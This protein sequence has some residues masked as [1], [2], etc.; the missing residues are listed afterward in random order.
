[1]APS[2]RNS[3]QSLFE[4]MM[5]PTSMAAS[6]AVS[7]SGA[8]IVSGGSSNMASTGGPADSSDSLLVEVQGENSAYYKAYV[9]DIFEGE[10]LLRFEDDWQPESKFPFARVRLPPHP[11]A[12]SSQDESASSIAHYTEGEEIEVFSRASDQ[13]SC[14]WWRAVIKMIKGDFHVVEYLGWETTY[15]EIVPIERLR[16]KSQEPPVNKMSFNKID[17]VLPNEIKEYYAAT[18]ED[19][20]PELHADFKNAIN[21]AKINFE[22]ESGVLRVLSCDPSTP[23]RA[24]MLQEMHFRNISQRANLRKRTEEAARYLEATRI[25]T[26]SVYTEEFC[27]TEDLMGLAIGAHGANIQ[28]ARKIEGVVN[29]E[30]LEDSCKFKVT[31]DTQEAALKARQMLEYAEVSSQVPRSLVGKVIGKNGRFIQE[32]VDKSGVVRVKIEGDNEPEPTVAREEGSVPFIFVGTKDAI[33]NAKMLLEYHLMSLKKVEELRQEKLEIDQQLRTIHGPDRGEYRD[34]YRGVGRDH[35]GSYDSDNYH[36][37][38]HEYR[39]SYH[40][41]GGPNRRDHMEGYQRSSGSGHHGGYR[42]HQGR[43]GGGYVARGRGGGR[44]SGP[45]GRGGNVRMEHRNDREGSETSERSG[46]FRGGSFY[47]NQRGVNTESRGGRGAYRGDRG[48][49]RGT[50]DR[51]NI[52]INRGGNRSLNTV[53]SDGND[54]QLPQKTTASGDVVRDSV[55]DNGSS[56]GG[57]GRDSENFDKSSNQSTSSRK[58]GNYQSR[59]GRNDIDRDG[60]RKGGRRGGY[61]HNSKG[62]SKDSNYDGGKS[63]VNEDQTNESI[64]SSR[65]NGQSAKHG[66]TSSVGEDSGL[67][68]LSSSDINKSGISLT[69]DTKVS[70]ISGT[71]K[72]SSNSSKPQ[73]TNSVSS[74]HQHHNGGSS[75]GAKSDHFSEST[76][77]S[78]RPNTVGNGNSTSSAAPNTRVAASMSSAPSSNGSNVTTKKDKITMLNNSSKTAV[79]ASSGDK[80]NKLV[81]T[82]PPLEKGIAS[83]SKVIPGTPSK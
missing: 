21:A 17:I 55:P 53:L 14:G 33:E 62:S 51:G 9:K 3:N 81:G 19:K 65:V 23:R 10:I 78:S 50:Q 12:S 27:V 32:I 43:G 42:D 2:Q 34:D 64:A 39:D 56:R 58:G 60:D 47:N 1:L 49:G 26:S 7:S 44:G 80:T 69:S 28:Q 15:T 76:S 38:S 35:R 61:K 40:S 11:I 37:Q 16:K 68:S 71:R 5:N 67:S 22:K 45:R 13:E 54:P 59:G 41:T 66:G 63:L 57:H 72:S 83:V 30:L 75:G 46:T 20:Q 48:S 36:R 73:I 31:A 24:A 25:Q 18:P 8:N 77:S 6:Q 70:S 79:T 82:V 74:Q 4:K 52:P 29:V